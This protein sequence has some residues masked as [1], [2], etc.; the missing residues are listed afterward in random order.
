MHRLVILAALTIA[1]PAMA[2]DQALK[3]LLQEKFQIAEIFEAASIASEKCPGLHVIEDAVVATAADLGFTDDDD[4]IYSPEYNLW[5]ARGQTN[6]KIGYEKD[7]VHW[8]ESVWHFLGPDH[9]PM[10][11][12]A[13]LK[14]Q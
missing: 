7:P 13:L 8:C 9:P 10:I 14:K 11:K 6:A 12:R 4:I 2:G 3:H 5:A 1:T